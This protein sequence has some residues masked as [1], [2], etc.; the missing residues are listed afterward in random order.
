MSLPPSVF[1]S[2]SSFV[3]A[4]C[5]SSGLMAA[6]MSASGRLPSLAWFSGC[7]CTLPNTA[8]PPPSQR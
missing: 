6:S 5:A 1:S 3:R 4:K 8:A 2:A 7:G